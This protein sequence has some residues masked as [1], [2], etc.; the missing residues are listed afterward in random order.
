MILQAETE[1]LR[2]RR[3]QVTNQHSPTV[4]T[5]NSSDK[6]ENINMICYPNELSYYC[7]ENC[8]EFLENPSPMVLVLLIMFVLSLT[9][10]GTLMLKL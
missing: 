10:Q 6:R 3:V 8:K 5:E 9:T 1:L 2:K 4:S 7:S